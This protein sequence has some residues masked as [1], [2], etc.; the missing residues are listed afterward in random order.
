MSFAFTSGDIEQISALLGSQPTVQEGAWLWQMVNPQNRQAQTVTI[1][2]NVRLGGGQTGSIIAVQT[3]HGYFELHNCTHFVLF[4]PDEVIFLSA[5]P[6][7]ISSMV[8]GRNC[9]CSMF[10]PIQRELL[11]SDFTALDPAVLMSAMQLSI[12]EAVL[13]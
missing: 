4:E 3:K 10:A 12:A 7:V 5:G 8:I 13:L 2:N 1:Y 11:H 6:Q 9:T